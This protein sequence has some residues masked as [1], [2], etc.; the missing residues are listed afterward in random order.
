MNNWRRLYLYLI[1]FLVIVFWSIVFVLIL[2][3]NPFQADWLMLLLF[4][5]SFLI[6]SSGTLAL[7]G[8]YLR[9]RLFSKSPSRADFLVAL[10]QGFLTGIFITGTLLFVA[11]GFFNWWTIVLFFIILLLLELLLRA[12]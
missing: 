1:L 7:F 12:R 5:G 3:V 9:S 11:F 6:A 4:F 10:R 8:F 2:S